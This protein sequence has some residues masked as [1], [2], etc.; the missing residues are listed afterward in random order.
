MNGLLF[1][2]GINS[3]KIGN[4]KIKN[5]S[6]IANK[7]VESRIINK[8]KKEK[9]VKNVQRKNETK[10]KHKRKIRRRINQATNILTMSLRGGLSTTN[11]HVH[12]RHSPIKTKG[13]GE[14]T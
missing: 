7:A 2:K 5:K 8:I 4:N 13:E 14:H 12:L 3:I 9:K 10:N 11:I 1:Q 6:R